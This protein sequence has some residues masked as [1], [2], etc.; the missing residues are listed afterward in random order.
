[1]SHIQPRTAANDVT[2]GP[3]IIVDNPTT[4]IGAEM[5]PCSGATATPR[6]GHPKAAASSKSPAK[7]KRRTSVDGNP[8]KKRR[9]GPVKSEQVETLSFGPASL[10]VLEFPSGN[11]PSLW[12]SNK[13]DLVILTSKLSMVTTIFFDQE[14]TICIAIQDDG[15]VE[16]SITRDSSR[17]SALIDSLISLDV[18]EAP[19]LPPKD[20]LVSSPINLVDPF[21]SAPVPESE[22]PKTH[23]SNPISSSSNDFPG[24]INN[25]AHPSSTQVTETLISDSSIPGLSIHEPLKT[26]NLRGPGR[27]SQHTS[28]GDFARRDTRSPSTSS[29]PSAVRT[30]PSPSGLGKPDIA[31]RPSSSVVSRDHPIL[32]VEQ[33][34]FLFGSNHVP[35]PSSR[36]SSPPPRTKQWDRQWDGYPRETSSQRSGPL[37]HSRHWDRNW[38]NYPQERFGQRSG[39]PIHHHKHWDINWDTYPRETGRRRPTYPSPEGRSSSPYVPMDPGH[40]PFSGRPVGPGRTKDPRRRSPARRNLQVFPPASDYHPQIPERPQVSMPRSSKS[41]LPTFKKIRSPPGGSTLP[42]LSSAATASP[43]LPG[44][45]IHESRTMT[46]SWPTRPDA[47]VHGRSYLG[48][49]AGGDY[50][51]SSSSFPSTSTRHRFYDQRDH[52]YRKMESSSNTYSERLELYSSKKSSLT[53]YMMGV[54]SQRVGSQHNPSKSHPSSGRPSDPPPLPRFSTSATVPIIKEEADLIY[55]FR[56]QSTKGPIPFISKR[57]SSPPLHVPSAIP[58]PDNLLKISRPSS[59]DS[60]YAPSPTRHDTHPLNVPCEEDTYMLDDVPFS[61]PRPSPAIVSSTA[62]TPSTMKPPFLAMTHQGEQNVNTTPQPPS[63]YSWSEKERNWPN[64]SQ[65]VISGKAGSGRA[66]NTR[67]AGLDRQPSTTTT[68]RADRQH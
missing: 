7:R 63:M 33:V 65:P 58:P 31:I 50:N 67:E 34:P 44:L 1:M 56:P 45:H 49:S 23:A 32:D 43:R 28:F 16:L 47:Q 10:P 25:A 46:A 11:T 21:P 66:S 64:T 37:H 5:E 2:K 20:V 35:L 29:F 24:T 57:S 8:S 30:S 13:T 22:I 42:P 62:N 19:E 59:P 17:Q 14:S 26:W 41:G 15:E 36:S 48:H 3:E 9:S 55:P 68:G 38:D 40:H 52:P 18:P 4:V 39:S 60:L 53:E 51:H 54:L 6:K 61:P 12:A 27:V